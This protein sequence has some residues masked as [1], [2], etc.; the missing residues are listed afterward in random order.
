MAIEPLGSAISFQS[1]TAQ[2]ITPV[3]KTSNEN[4]D[5]SAK[6][7]NNIVDNM[8]AAVKSTDEKN[9]QSDNQSGQNSQYSQNSSSKQIKKAVEEM[10]KKMNNS[11]VLFG[12]HEATNRITIKIVDKVTQ[13]VIKEIP[14]EKTLD[15]F[16]KALELAGLLVDEKG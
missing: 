14:P 1:Q 7:D 16:A 3:Q 9:S 11:E 12:V 15:M 8:T 10:N 4:T 6:E 5:V 2:A 13:K